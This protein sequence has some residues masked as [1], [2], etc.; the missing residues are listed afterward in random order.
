MVY[1]NIAKNGNYIY[2]PVSLAHICLCKI[3]TYPSFCTDVSQ[4]QLNLVIHI[5]KNI[6]NT[7]VVATARNLSY[8]N[9]FPEQQENLLDREVR[10]ISTAELGDHREQ[11]HS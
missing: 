6:T 9:N 5:E 4:F 1:K 7:N 2:D 3:L 11:H 10:S 8:Q